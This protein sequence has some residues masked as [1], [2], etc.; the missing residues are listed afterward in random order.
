MSS[1]KNTVQETGRSFI[2]RKK[3]QRGD[4]HG[5]RNKLVEQENLKSAITDHYRRN[6]HITDWDKGKVITSETNK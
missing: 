6:N 2:T 1:T 4:S 3:E 5:H